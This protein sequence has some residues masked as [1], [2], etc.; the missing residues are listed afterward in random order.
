[1]DATMVMAGE[2]CIGEFGDRRLC[3]TGSLLYSR[4][5]ERGTVCLRQLGDAR[6]TQRRFHRLLEHQGVTHGEIIRHGSARTA[7]AASGRHVLAIQDTSELDYSAHARRTGGLGGISK[8]QGCGLFIH[9]VLAVDAESNDCLGIAHAVTWVR[10]TRRKT[11]RERRAIEEKESM[12]W[13]EGAQGAGRCLEQAALVTVVA[14]RESDIYEEWDRI[15]DGHTHL[16]TRARCD[17]QIEEGGTLFEWLARQP[18]MA[19]TSRDVPARPAGKAYRSTDGARKRA[20]TAHRARMELRYGRVTI[21]RPQGCR[22]RQA[23]IVLS[24]VELRERPETVVRD[25]QPVHWILLTTHDVETPEQALQVV[26]W[27]GQRWQIEQLFRTLK[28]QGLDLESSQ[29]EEASELVK[30]ASIATLAA[31]R[32]L[33]LINAR[34][35]QTQQPA[36]DAFDNDEMVV[37]EKLQDKLQGR[38]SKQKNPH[39]IHSMAWAAWTIARLGGWTGYA[40]EAKP[41]PITMLHG[42][43]RFDGMMQGWKLAKIWA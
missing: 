19:C 26:Q 3:K 32:T 6:A 43:R 39:P 20:R 21:R 22:A 30:L 33:Q 14:D 42:L 27:Y 4:I 24:V 28:R 2:F 10:D 16:L 40:R 35:G 13:L 8:N 5:V 31:A 18:V 1:M 37:L 36:S 9:P 23:S 11:Q 38:T 34:D 25:E 41:G 12:C 17:R 29:L 7:Q 15:P